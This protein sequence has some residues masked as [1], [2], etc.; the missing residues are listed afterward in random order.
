M[1]ASVRLVALIFADRVDVLVD[2][3][4]GDA[5]FRRDAVAG[6]AYHKTRMRDGPVHMS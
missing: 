6:V 3:V 1:T 2:G 4:G 5:D